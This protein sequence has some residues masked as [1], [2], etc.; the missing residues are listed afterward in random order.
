MGLRVPGVHLAGRLDGL[1]ELRQY[2]RSLAT[3]LATKPRPPPPLDPTAVRYLSV[4]GIRANII[5]ASSP[6]VLNPPPP[7]LYAWM[8]DGGGLDQVGSVWPP[9][10][11]RVAAASQSRR[12]VRSWLLLSLSTGPP[13]LRGYV[14]LPHS[15][16]SRARI[17][18][19]GWWTW[20]K[21][22]E[23]SALSSSLSEVGS[24]RLRPMEDVVAWGS[25]LRGT[26]LVVTPSIC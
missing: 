21:T 24:P 8:M 10:P 20:S 13:F 4:P 9:D 22:T 5:V 14:R 26:K 18:R 16:T 11:S 3:G 19:C 6:V 1:A 7:P 17:A 23:N 2:R 25:D 15:P 12:M